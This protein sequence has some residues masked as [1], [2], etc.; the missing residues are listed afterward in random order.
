[1][2]GVALKLWLRRVPR[3]CFIGDSVRLCKDYVPR[4][5]I[6]GIFVCKEKQICLASIFMTTDNE[7]EKQSSFL[8]WLYISY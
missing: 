3:E 8:L 5:H 7:R 2:Q 1:M 6:W 4:M